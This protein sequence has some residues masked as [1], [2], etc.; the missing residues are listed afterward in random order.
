MGWLLVGAGLILQIAGIVFYIVF[1]KVSSFQFVY[2]LDFIDKF[3]FAKLFLY[4]TLYCYCLV[5][6]GCMYWA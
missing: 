2:L 3:F 6:R 1:F 5:L 4:M